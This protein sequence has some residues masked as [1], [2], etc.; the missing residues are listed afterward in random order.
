MN[1]IYR[2]TLENIESTEL[3]ETFWSVNLL[4]F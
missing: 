4:Y 2:Q 1:K 3:E